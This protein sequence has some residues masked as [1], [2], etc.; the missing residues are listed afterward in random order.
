MYR[1]NFHS[2]NCFDSYFDKVVCI[3]LPERKAH[4]NKVFEAW[5]LR[6]VEYFDAFL[7]TQYTHE[8]FIKNGFL[9]KL[10]Q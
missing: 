1:V 4:M 6:K 8:D 7:R 9:E 10:S 2:T 3:C 5:G